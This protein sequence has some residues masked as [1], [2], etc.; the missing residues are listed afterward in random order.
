MQ[1]FIQRGVGGFPEQV[2]GAYEAPVDAAA[3]AVEEEAVALGAPDAATLFLVAVLAGIN[4]KAIAGGYGDERG[5]VQFH[6]A[7]AAAHDAPRES[8]A[9]L[10][11]TT[12]GEQRVVGAIQPAGGKPTGEGHLH[13]VEVARALFRLQRFACQ[14]GIYRAAVGAGGGGHVFRAFKAAFNLEAV[15]PG[16]KHLRHTVERA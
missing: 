15:Y 10:A 16:G 13:G 2:A 1:V 12:V 5:R 8:P 7:L 6:P 3:L 9:F 11:E 14:G 4:H